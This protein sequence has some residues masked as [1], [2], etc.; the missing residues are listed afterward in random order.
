MTSFRKPAILFVLADAKLRDIYLARFEHDGWEVDEAA[1]LLDAERKAVQLRPAIL[2]IGQEFLDNLEANFT[3]F[4]SLPT[5]LKARIV[6]AGQAFSREAVS[7]M[8]RAGAHDIVM[9]AHVSPQELSKR[10][11][12]LIE[13]DV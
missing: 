2:F 1:S 6:V 12:K 13:K 9:T 4:K 3:R 7:T 5:L 8:V 10:L 11:H